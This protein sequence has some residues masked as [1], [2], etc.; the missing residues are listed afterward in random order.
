[1]YRDRTLM[2]NRYID[3]EYANQI[4]SIILYLRKENPRET[5]SL[6]FNVPGADLR[7]ALAVYDLIQQTKVNCEIETVNLALCA[8][9]GSV[10]CAAGTKGKRSAFPNARFLLQRVGM[11]EVFQGQATD[12][13]LEV[14]NNKEC[15]NRM[16]LVSSPWQGAQYR[17][18]L[19]PT[20][21]DDKRNK[22]KPLSFRLEF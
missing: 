14:K 10:L 1:M 8:G 9:M 18:I 2:I 3:Q 20:D 6:Y 4:I 7:P 16:E 15:N 17:T 5:M 21:Y 22:I 19:H 13:A 12:I 11:E